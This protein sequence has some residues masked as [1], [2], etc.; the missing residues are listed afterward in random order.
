MDFVDYGDFATFLHIQA[1]FFTF[2]SDHFYVWVGGGP[3]KQKEQQTE[4]IARWK[5]ISSWLSVFG[6]PGI[7]AVGTDS[8]S[9]GEI[10]QD[11]RTA[12]NIVLQAV[13]HGNHQ[14][15]GATGRRIGP[16][17]TTIDHMVGN[18]K[19]NC[20]GQKCGRNSPIWLFCALI[21]MCG[22]L[23]GLHPV[24][25]YLGE[26]QKCRLGRR[27]SEFWGVHEP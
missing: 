8:R 15:S 20:L 14:S 6:E 26:R 3:S 18:K 2:L 19:A 27:G 16:F 24:K 5:V 17:R 22:S 25:V 7:I 10:F 13:S 9:I 11:F 21:P 23:R 1:T 4:E 12:R